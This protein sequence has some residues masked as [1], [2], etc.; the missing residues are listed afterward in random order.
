MAAATVPL[1]A[2]LAAVSCL[3][4]KELSS[5]AFALTVSHLGDMMAYLKRG[6]DDLTRM[7]HTD[8]VKLVPTSKLKIIQAIL[9]DF[10]WLREESKT[11]DSLCD[12]LTELAQFIN[13]HTQ[14]IGLAIE[15]FNQLY[16]RSWRTLDVTDHMSAIK[17]HSQM[18]EETFDI[19]KDLLPS[20]LAVA[21]TR[22]N[23]L[24][25]TRNPPPLPPPPKAPTQLPKAL[26]PP[27]QKDS[28]SNDPTPDASWVALEPAK[29]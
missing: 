14:Q 7:I 16:F 1:G 22:P 18:L 19:L 10:E 5:Q 26:L 2:G 28:S 8:L 24:K 21:T 9:I 20:C 29:K 23:K 15:H 25:P 13:Y 17:K 11:V 6:P 12:Q 4:V 3:V 27:P